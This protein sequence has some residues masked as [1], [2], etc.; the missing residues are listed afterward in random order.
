VATA[1][2]LLKFGEGCFKRGGV[3]RVL[4]PQLLLL[5]I[6]PRPFVGG[7]GLHGTAPVEQGG[8]FATNCGSLKPLQEGLAADLQLTCGHLQEFCAVLEAIL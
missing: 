3:R 6:K 8:P 4:F 1:V 5:L 2:L 7:G